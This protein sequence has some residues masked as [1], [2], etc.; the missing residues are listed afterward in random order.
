MRRI[1]VGLVVTLTLGLLLAPLGA[2]AQDPGKIARIGI[3]VGG[4]G[5]SKPALSRGPLILIKKTLRD[6]GWVEGRN[7]HFEG[8]YS[9]GKLDRFPEI[10][11]AHV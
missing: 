5:P 9:M 3:L 8:R 2:E 1:N 7:V 6:L 11:R 4:P 10:G